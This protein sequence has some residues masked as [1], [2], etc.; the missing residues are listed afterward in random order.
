[1]EKPAFAEDCLRAAVLITPLFAPRG[2]A[3]GLIIDRDTLRR[4]GAVTLRAKEGGF[5]MRTA[6][7]T[8]EDRPWSPAPPARWGAAAKEDPD[9]GEDVSSAE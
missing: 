4:T 8:G 6:R 3:A 7:A 5:E 2:C 9:T 1:L